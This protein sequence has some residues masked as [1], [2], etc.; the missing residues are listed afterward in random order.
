MEYSQISNVIEVPKLFKYLVQL[1]NLS[2]IT[3]G[4]I[5]KDSKP[6]LNFNSAFIIKFT[7]DIK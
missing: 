1:L 5:Y 2:S 4:Y 3:V 7:F 6:Q